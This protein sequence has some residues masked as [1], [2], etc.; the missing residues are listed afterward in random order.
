MKKAR[1]SRPIAKKISTEA[2][3]VDS[4]IQDTNIAWALPLRQLAP[5]NWLLT[6]EM[7]YALDLSMAL[8]EAR[9]RKKKSP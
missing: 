1:K 5:K 3:A 6:R 2:A 4:E 8:A 7:L 9:N